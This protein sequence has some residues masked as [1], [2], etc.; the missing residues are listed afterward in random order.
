VGES[1][2]IG[3]KVNKYYYLYK[4]QDYPYIKF[5]RKGGVNEREKR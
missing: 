4:I 2:E 5:L 1:L 3:K